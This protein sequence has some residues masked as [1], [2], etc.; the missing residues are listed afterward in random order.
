MYIRI[1]CTNFLGQLPITDMPLELQ[2]APADDKGA[3][4]TNNSNTRTNNHNTRL[5][6]ILILIRNNK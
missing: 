3:R 6:I 4:R 1:S 5:L 2:G